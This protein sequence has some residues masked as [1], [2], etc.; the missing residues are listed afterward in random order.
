MPMVWDDTTDEGTFYS[1]NHFIN[2][3][4]TLREG[5]E[6]ADIDSLRKFNC[7]TIIT[8]FNKIG[9][10]QEINLDSIYSTKVKRNIY[11]DNCDAIL[12]GTIDTAWYHERTGISNLSEWASTDCKFNYYMFSLRDG[13]LLWRI[14]VRG[15][16]DNYTSLDDIYFPPLDVAISSGIDYFF[17][18][19]P[20][21][22]KIP[23]N[24]PW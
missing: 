16:N 23:I 24:Q 6:L 19:F 10:K 9:D 22:K 13:K 5:I 8:M 14:R 2:K 3:I 15:S 21:K 4:Y 1:T 18:E 12:V 20:F 17:D 7:D 11:E